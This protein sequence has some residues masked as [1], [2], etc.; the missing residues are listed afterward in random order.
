M[1]KRGTSSRMAKNKNW[2][3]VEIAI[4]SE[5]YRRVVED[6]QE[7]DVNVFYEGEERV[8]DRHEKECHEPVGITQPLDRFSFVGK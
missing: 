3:S 8:E 7:E 6:I 1:Q 5:F 4:V 2:M